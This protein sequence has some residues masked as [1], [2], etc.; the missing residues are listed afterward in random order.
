MHDNYAARATHLR[1]SRPT[2]PTPHRVKF[3]QHVPSTGLLALDL[4]VP[5]PHLRGRPKD[6]RILK[7]CPTLQWH[8]PSAQVCSNRTL[9]IA[10]PMV[11]WP[12]PQHFLDQMRVQSLLRPQ[13][14]RLRY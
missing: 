9:E 2:S 4:E 7:L 8:P 11:D 14:H 1:W 3:V 10:S 13:N 5:Y 6:T 12:L